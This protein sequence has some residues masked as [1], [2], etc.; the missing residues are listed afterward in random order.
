VKRLYPAFRLVFLCVFVLTLVSIA[1]S[2]YATTFL[3]SSP[4]TLRL[5][6]GCMTTWKMGVGALLGLLGGKAI[7]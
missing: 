3:E 2:V 1:V 4:E 5:V 6:E 7:K